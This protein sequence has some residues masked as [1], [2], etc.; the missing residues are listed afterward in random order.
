MIII[1]L[2]DDNG[3]RINVFVDKIQIIGP[4]SS[5]NFEKCGSYIR[6]DTTDDGYI[7]VA[8]SPDEILKMIPQD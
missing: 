8:E 6:F 1:Q 4:R 7:G 2:T 5:P 3:K